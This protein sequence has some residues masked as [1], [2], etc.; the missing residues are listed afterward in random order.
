MIRSVNRAA[1]AAMCVA[2]LAGCSQQYAANNPGATS[3][4][5]GAGL[6][7]AGGALIGA[8]ASGG[9]ARGTVI[10]ALG[11]AAAGA[12]GGY[13]WNQHLEAQK[14]A[15]QRTAQGTGVQVSQTADNRL[16]LN[17]PADAGFATGSATLN[18]RLYPILDQLGQGLQQNPTETVQIIGY[19]DSTGSNAINYPL[20]DNRAAS[21]KTYLVSRG[22]SGQRIATRGMGPQDPV[23]S[24]ATAAGRA[25]N[26]R[27]DIYVAFPPQPAG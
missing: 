17:V 9:Q 19:T 14:Q 15:L 2:M 13:L 8:L 5:T 22:I 26:R 27:V 24:N 3:A 4:A 1:A 21:V 10:G 16:K 11:G 12:L 7:A 6:G 23:A 25:A 20:S 18:P